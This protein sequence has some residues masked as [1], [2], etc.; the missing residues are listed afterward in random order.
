MKN[1]TANKIEREVNCIILGILCV[2]G[3][4]LIALVWIFLK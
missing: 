2:I 4:A 1:E 3:A